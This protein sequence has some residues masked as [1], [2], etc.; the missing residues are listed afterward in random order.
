DVQDCLFT[1]RDVRERIGWSDTQL[2]V[3][4]SRLVDMEY[5][6]TRY[7]PRH[8]QS[9]L[10]ELLYE[11]PIQNV[12]KH[13]PGLIEVE[14]LKRLYDANRPAGAKPSKDSKSK[15]HDYGEDRSG[16]KSNRSAPGRG[17]VGGRS[18]QKKSASSCSSDTSESKAENNEKRKAG[19]E[20]REAS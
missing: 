3:H 13:L 17:A 14:E 16:Q 19:D 20:K 11:G 2:K 9:Y 6:A 12:G 8:S 4:L 15:I 10:Y 5:L 18:N 1:R 7:N